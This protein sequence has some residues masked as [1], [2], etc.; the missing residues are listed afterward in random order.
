MSLRVRPACEADLDAISEMLADFTRGHPA[1]H[2]PRRAALRDAYLGANPVAHLLVAVRAERV[3][4]MGQ[5]SRI[6]DMFWAM[7]GGRPE[8]LYV[9]PEARGQGVAAAI[10]A[11]ICDEVRRAGG[12]Y[13]W[14]AY[15]ADVASLYERFAIASDARECHLSGVAFQ[16]FAALA[17]QPLRTIV[18]NLPDR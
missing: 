15:S 18:R 9:R 12:E 16:R 8:Y 11:A 6:F 14:A 3:I 10:I 1:E 5:W 13:L 17:G 7:H 4:G 2:V